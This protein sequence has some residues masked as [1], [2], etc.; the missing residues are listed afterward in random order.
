VGTG[1]EKIQTGEGHE[2]VWVGRLN[3]IKGREKAQVGM[4]I[5]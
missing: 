2:N 5:G 4:G 3:P 1:G